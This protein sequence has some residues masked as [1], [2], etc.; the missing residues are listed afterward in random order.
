ML[1]SATTAG[2]R[3]SAWAA[4]A[5]QAGALIATG[6]RGAVLGL[7]AAVAVYAT[8]RW[9]R[10][11][12]IGLAAVALFAGV[13]I[14]ISPARPIDTTAAGRLQLWRIVLPRVREA[15]LV[16]QG[17]APSR[18]A[19]RSRQRSAAREGRATGGSPD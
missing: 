1:A 14:I 11:V 15:P 17:P 4:L 8:L 18:C 9:S 6:S 5:F 12:R 10:R 3:R 7:A 19:S 2:R 16:G 13:A